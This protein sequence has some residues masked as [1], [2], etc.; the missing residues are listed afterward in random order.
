VRTNNWQRL[1]ELFHATSQLGDAER[2][3]Y[4]ARECAGDDG[5]RREVESLVEAL[6]SEHSFIEE[7]ALSLGI[8]VLSGDLG[9]SLAGSSIGHYNVVR[10]LGRGGMGE[11]YLAEDS[12]LERPVALKFI[13]NNFVGGEWAREQLMKEARAVARLENSN[14]CAVYGVEETE[15]HNF[16]VMQY[17]EGETLSALLSRE[18]LEPE[19]AL[20]LAEQIIGALS[21][22][23]ARGV[24][25]RDV[26]PQNI[27]VAADG[28][29]KVLDFGLAK[30][31]R[32]QQDAEGAG[33]APGQTRQSGAV[34]GTVAY[35]S[36]EQAR[37][38]EMDCRSDIFSFGIVLH[39]MLGGGNPFRRETDEETISAIKADETAPLTGLPPRLPRGV[40]NVVRKCLAKDRGLRYET[41]DQLLQDLRDIR[42]VV[43][44]APATMKMRV[45]AFVKHV[46][47]KYYAAAALALVCLLLASAGFVYKKLSEVHTL[48]ILPITNN[49]GD[50]AAD[51]LSE[52]L[53]R[54]LFDKF[55]YLPRLKI[56]LPSAVPPG[57]S[58][59]AALAEIGRAL[60]TDAVLSGQV[61]KQGESLRLHVGLLN[62][63]DAAQIWESTFDLDSAN[64]FALQDNITREVASKLGLWLIAGEQKLLTKRQTDSEEALHL[65]MQGRRYLR[66]RKNRDDVQKAINC[67]EQAVSIDPSFAKAYAGLADSYVLTTNVGYGP[68]R[69][70]EAMDKAGYAARQAIEAGDSLPEAHT[71]MGLFELNYGWDWSRAE[72]E[73]RRAIELNPNYAPAHYGYSNVLFVLRR[74]D[75]SLKESDIAKSLDPYSPLAD[76]N[77]GR[78]L[79]YASQ[80]DEAAEYFRQML[81]Q[82]PK[83]PQCLHMLGLVQLQQGLYPQAVETLEKL[84]AIKPLHA[85]AALGYAYAKADRRDDAMRMIHELEQSSD[86]I[87]PHE[88]ALVYIGL[89]DRDQAFSMLEKAYEDK[90]AGLIY[91]T[92]DPIYDDLRPDPRFAELAR[93]LK[94]MP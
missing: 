89:G 51:N 44:P 70:K 77:Y 40:E 82:D 64:I 88:K 9:G 91:L 62:T 16:I 94:L 35:M 80:Y 17:V 30:F 1:E 47:F 37:G 78:A 60:K 69:T 2:A 45:R 39:E 14:I 25:H 36:P 68:L 32:Q 57:K 63:A 26:K 48:A 75:E 52:G 76:M 13:A 55:S 42:N 18:P 92:T 29:V 15:S 50:P 33:G 83:C 7:P 84:H 67:F 24:I 93:R 61:F 73:F 79:Y 87:S 86:P 71:S 90:F 38:E 20:D 5:L 22:A 58:E 21:A 49:S 59:P 85:A 27:I 6:E 41:T 3:D 65:Y 72:Q 53:T 8:K 23:H 43:V 46:H 19:R 12:V 4:L 34:I 66:L 56:K 81:E 74:F 28:Q 31:V 11:V 10:L 54:N